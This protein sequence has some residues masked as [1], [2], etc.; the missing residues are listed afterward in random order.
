MKKICLLLLC[1]VSVI[2][3]IAQNNDSLKAIQTA[4]I[5]KDPRLDILAK[6]QAEL[7]NMAI[8]IAA[9]SA[10]GYRLQV[11]STNDRE[12]AMKTKSELLQRFPE[13]KVYMLYQLPYL[14]IRFGNFKTKQEAEDYLNDLSKVF[15]GAVFI[16]RD[17]IEV[18]PEP[19]VE[20]Q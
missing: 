6:K 14:K 8:K 20:T 3:I 9:R 1:F 19:A 4:Y 15:P 2:K 11:L 18:K 5:H 13:Q 16:V 12:L 10:W 17:V 7:N